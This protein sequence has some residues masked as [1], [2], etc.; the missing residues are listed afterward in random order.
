[1]LS[2]VCSNTTFGCEGRQHK[3]LIVRTE[4]NGLL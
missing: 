2:I 4:A 1:M 3:I